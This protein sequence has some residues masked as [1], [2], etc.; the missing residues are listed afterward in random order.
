QLER[1]APYY[2]AVVLCPALLCAALS[3]L[4]FLHPN[5]RIVLFIISSHLIL[6]VIFIIS[7]LKTLPT[8]FKKRPRILDFWINEV[9]ITS[10]QLFVCIVMIFARKQREVKKISA[11]MSLISIILANLRW[12]FVA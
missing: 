3:S 5:T 8:N 12:I 2:V 7:V 9:A 1:H 6:L 11:V 4:A 10:I